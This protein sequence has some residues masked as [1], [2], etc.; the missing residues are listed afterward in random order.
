[1]VGTVKLSGFD[2]L[3]DALVA[4]VSRHPMTEEELVRLLP[5]WP[6]EDVFQTLEQLLQTERLQ[7]VKRYGQR[8]WASRRA[9]YGWRPASVR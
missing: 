3:M 5:D 7:V 2:S 9:R 6:R 8:F 4:V 1:L